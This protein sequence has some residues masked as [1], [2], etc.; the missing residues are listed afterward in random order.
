M[1]LVKIALGKYAA[2]VDLSIAEKLKRAD[3]AL[4]AATSHHIAVNQSYRSAETQANLY[5]NRKPGQR[6]APPGKSYHEKGLAVDVT[7]WQEAQP[8]LRAQGFKN[9][10]QDDL[11]HFSI[12]EFTFTTQEKTG[13][14]LAGILLVAAAF[15]FIISKTQGQ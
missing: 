1:N 5:A 7:N 3:A 4:F 6:V 10:L 2:T 12:G 9:N 8:Y 11:G 15:Y 13:I 14:G